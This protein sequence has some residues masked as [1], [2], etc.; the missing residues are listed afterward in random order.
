MLSRNLLLAGFTLCG[1][2]AFSQ[3]SST[4]DPAT[5][6]AET[7]IIEELEASGAV[8]PYKVMVIPFEPKLYMSD[9]DRDIAKEQ[10]LSYSHI[11]P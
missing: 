11:D 5:E 8:D 3:I 6:P 4:L 10:G 2:S 7:A 1:I 9:I